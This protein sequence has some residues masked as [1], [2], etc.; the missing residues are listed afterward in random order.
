MTV[1]KEYIHIFGRTRRKLL[2]EIK[3]FQTTQQRPPL[4]PLTYFNKV[5]PVS[6]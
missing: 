6:Y 3:E 4:C 2:K 5:L 1:D